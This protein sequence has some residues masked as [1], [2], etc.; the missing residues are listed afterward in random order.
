M[1]GA[2]CADTPA[3][4]S[5]CGTSKEAEDPE[6]KP[7]SDSQPELSKDPESETEAGA[8]SNPA[9]EPAE[10]A[11]PGVSSGRESKPN[12]PH[13]AA[14]G[15]GNPV[16]QRYTEDPRTGSCTYP[17]WAAQITLGH[18]CPRKYAQPKGATAPA[19]CVGTKATDTTIFP[20]KGCAIILPYTPEVRRGRWLSCRFGSPRGIG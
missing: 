18:M 1:P 10:D 11:Q 17:S 2:C 14:S 15:P 4:R 5:R 9:S 7:D 6:L 8:E 13:I 12:L 20:P 16:C 3:A 19:M